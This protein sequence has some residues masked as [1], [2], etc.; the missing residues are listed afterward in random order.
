MVETPD[1]IAR[2]GAVHALP[3]IDFSVYA[4]PVNPEAIHVVRHRFGMLIHPG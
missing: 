4:K 2:A 1:S 3:R